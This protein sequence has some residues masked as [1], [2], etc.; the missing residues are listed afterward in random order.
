MRTRRRKTGAKVSRHL[1]LIEVDF[2]KKLWPCP[3]CGYLSKPHQMNIKREYYGL[4]RIKYLVRFCNY[5]C[6]VCK[7]HFRS[8]IDDCWPRKTPYA[9]DIIDEAIELYDGGGRMTL[10]QVGRKMYEMHGVE[11][12]K[13]TI[14]DWW[15]NSVTN[16]IKREVSKS[17]KNQEHRFERFVVDKTDGWDILRT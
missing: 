7:R 3:K 16:K 13:S 6:V 17:K 9:W 14:H 8:T 2:R 5:Y 4:Y 11:I 10:D 12:P 15:I 1:R